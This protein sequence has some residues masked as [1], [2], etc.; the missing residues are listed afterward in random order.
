MWLRAGAAAHGSPIISADVLYVT[1]GLAER[2]RQRRP[3]VAPKASDLKPERPADG[4]PALLIDHSFAGL[5]DAQIV[6]I[7]GKCRDEPVRHQ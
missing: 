2:P 1:R 4:T 7:A 6:G 3:R 5:G